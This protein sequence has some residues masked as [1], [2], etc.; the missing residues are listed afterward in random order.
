M[1]KPITN[2]KKKAKKS[3]KPRTKE[4]QQHASFWKKMNPQ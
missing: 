2:P 1:N 3:Q 4:N